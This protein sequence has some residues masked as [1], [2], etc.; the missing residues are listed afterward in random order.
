M[1]K[2]YILFN[3]DVSEI[4]LVSEDRDFVRECLCDCFMADVDYQWYWEQMHTTCNPKS[5]NE[6]ARD[7]WNDMLQWYEDYMG[8]IEEEVI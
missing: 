2:V 3:Y 5:I 8:I 7:I 6:T 4:V 1:K